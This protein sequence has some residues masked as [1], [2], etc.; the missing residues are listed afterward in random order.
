VL[1]VS[2]ALVLS[3]PAVLT[4]NLPLIGWRNVVTADNLE[5]T[6]ADASYPATNLVNPSTVL[7]WLATSTAVQYLTVTFSGVTEVDYVG[8]ARHNFADAAI[9]V[10]VEALYDA[11]WTEIAEPFLP[12]DNAPILIR[13]EGQSPEAIR[14]KLAT[15]TAAAS[16]AV[17][18]VGKLLVMER[19][20]NIDTPHTPLT[21]GRVTEATP[22]F[23]EA[24]DYLGTIITSRRNEATEQ[25]SHISPAW[26]RA[27][28]D[29]FVSFAEESPF[30]YAWRPSQYPEEIGYAKLTDDPQPA[31]NPK[32]NRFSVALSMRGVLL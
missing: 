25:F 9:A 30:F 4:E 7:K 14:V 2:H 26:Y 13:F 19:G 22:A 8:L 29:P 16:L 31:V 6:S 28:F 20:V 5:A 1:V 23:S 10:S 11:V 21:F 12:G 32:T 3:Q 24:G 15:G 17:L 18:Y 27:Q